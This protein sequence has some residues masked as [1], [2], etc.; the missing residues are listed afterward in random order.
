MSSRREQQLKPIEQLSKTDLKRVKMAAKV[1][2]RAYA[3][4]SKFL[5]GAVVQDDRGKWHTGCNVEN[6]LFNIGM[7]AER[8]AIAKMVSRGGKRVRQV[9]IVGGAD[10]PSFPCGSCLQIINE[11]GPDAR[12]VAVN[13]RL[14]VFGELG[15]TDLYPYAFASDDLRM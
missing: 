5:V 12:V 9:V 7:C 6:A 3:P 4:Y 14:S 1:R 15:M 11:F 8:T 13:R 2:K 10:T